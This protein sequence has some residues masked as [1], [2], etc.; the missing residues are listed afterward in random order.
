GY[1]ANW[2]AIWAGSSY[3]DLFAA[4]SPLRHTWSLAIE[5]QFY[6]V[7]PLVVWLVLVRWRRAL[8]A[9][10]ALTAA[11]AAGSAAAAVRPPVSGAEPSRVD[12]GTDTRAAAI[13]FGAALALLVARRGPVHSA[14][15]RVGLEAAAV[16][17]VA[18]LAVAWTSMSG[19]GD[20]LY[21][22]GLA[23]CGL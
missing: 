8:G 9:M 10:L 4:P 17:A 11:P 22:G 14:G 21:R 20:G 23:A 7:W 5:E 12:Y 15:A 16:A 19:T 1:V 13:L 3:W 18:G 6:L 2:H